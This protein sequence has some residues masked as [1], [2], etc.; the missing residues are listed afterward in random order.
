M[1]SRWDRIRNKLPTGGDAF[2]Y[3]A[4]AAARVPLYSRPETAAPPVALLSY[5]VVEVDHEHSVWKGADREELL[6]V[7]IKTMKGREGYVQGDKIRSA[8][9]QRAYF[10]KV[11][12]KWMMY[13]FIAGD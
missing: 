4:I 1:T 10:K 12:G 2:S 6:W 5:D 3:S 13:V 9:D 7:K 8:V 11:R